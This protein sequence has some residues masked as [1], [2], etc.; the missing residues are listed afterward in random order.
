MSN[1]ISAVGSS[2]A[3]AL[4][5]K[6]KMLGMQSIVVEMTWT[7]HACSAVNASQGGYLMLS[8]R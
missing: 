2:R 6:R 7:V 3:E 1:A 8:H 5:C 4:A